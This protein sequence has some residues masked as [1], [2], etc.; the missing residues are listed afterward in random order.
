M[1]IVVGLS[2]FLAIFIVASTFAFTVAQ[3]RRELA[4]IR[5]AGGSGRQLR[6]LGE[7]LLLSVV[8]TVSG[9][10]V[11]LPVM[12]F[13][14]WLLTRLGFAPPGFAGQWQGWIV[15]VSAGTGVGIALLGV[16]AASGRAARIRPLEALRDTGKAARVMTLSR[17]L[18]GLFFGAGGVALMILVPAVGGEGAV[19]LSILSS[20]V[21]IVAF[22]ALGPLLVPAIGALLG[23]FH[24]RA[25]LGHLAR[26]NLRDAVR[27]SAS[28]AAPV[29]VLMG[30]VVATAGTLETMAEAARQE[31]NRVLAARFPKK[32]PYRSSYNHPNR[33]VR[34]R[35]STA[36]P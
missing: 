7:A 19:A 27:R 12:R 4:L 34:S 10:A 13:E 32:R 20:L 31:A 30:F 15:A 25:T 35:R 24:G 28:T 17:W 1:G 9:I 21:W 22:T 36:W 8:G 33:T 29:M 18:L 11:G 26:A 16:L 2:A 6:A 23:V 5:L 14:G 3:R